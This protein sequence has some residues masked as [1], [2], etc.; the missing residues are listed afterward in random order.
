MIIENRVT[1][2]R[3]FLKT[4]GRTKGLCSFQ[5]LFKLFQGKG[6]P[7]DVYD[8]LEEAGR[9]LAPSSDAIVTALMAKN[10]GLPGDGFFDIFRTKRS[11]EYAA[12]AGAHTLV[13][14]LTFAQREEMV[15]NERARVYAYASA[16]LW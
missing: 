16:H 12:I 10:N 1:A 5:N 15:M 2:V 7:I 13:R 14:E 6:E 3:T 9:Q 4:A 11:E 8:T